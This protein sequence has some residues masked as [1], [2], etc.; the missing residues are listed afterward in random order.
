MAETGGAAAMPGFDYGAHLAATGGAM[1]GMDP[2]GFGGAS[3]MAGFDS[4]MPGGFNDPAMMGGYAPPGGAMPGMG[5]DPMMPGGFNDPAMMGGYAPPGGAM[6][7]MGYDPMMPGGFNDP[8]MMGGYAPPGGAMPGMGYDPM[9]PGGFNDPAMMAGG[10]G[11]PGMMGYGDPAMMAGGYGDPGMMG[12]GDPA[13]MAGGY[14][15][16]G[17]MGYGDPAMM[18]GGYFDPGMMGPD[19]Y[20]DP[21]MMG[22]DPYYDPMNDPYYDPMNDPFYDPAMDP[23]N[24]PAMAL[25]PAPDPLDFQPQGIYG[26]PNSNDMSARNHGD[27]LTGRDGSDMM[28]S[29]GFQ[30]VVFNYESSDLPSLRAEAFEDHINGGFVDGYNPGNFNSTGPVWGL[31]QDD[32]LQFENLTLNYGNITLNSRAGDTM[33]YLSL[34]G[35]LQWKFWKRA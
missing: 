29:A 33:Q 12:Y 17:M 19:P 13:M 6:P 2:S 10:Y 24:N 20:Y 11:D 3:G 35:T 21:G 14:F 27:M 32:I 4:M 22:P 9:M 26:T 31:G 34:P 1:P 5:Y 28:W 15:D 25:G 16:P 7:G 23:A 18:A 8:A 30:N